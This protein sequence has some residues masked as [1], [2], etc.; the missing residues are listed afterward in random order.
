[1]NQALKVIEAQVELVYNELKRASAD[2]TLNQKS[3]ELLKQ[4]IVDAI[5]LKRII[6]LAR[7]S[8]QI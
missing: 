3:Y 4:A 8:N 6:E 5:D 2:R 1:M 7:L